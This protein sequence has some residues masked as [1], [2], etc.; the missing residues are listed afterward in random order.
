[1]HRRRDLLA[2]G[3]AEH[4]LRR[5]LRAG[6]LV[7]V[8]RGAYLTDAPDGPDRAGLLHLARLG[9][10]DLAP[11]AVVSHVSAALLHGLPVWNVPLARL[12]TTRPRRT[13]GRRGTVAH[14]H[15]ASLAVD[16]VVV[17]GALPVTTVA[18]TL[19]DLARTLP[20]AEAVAILDAALHR[21]LVTRDELADALARAT[22]WPGTP[23]AARAV[24]F[25]DAGS[26]SV[27]ESRSRVAM[28]LAGL[29]APVLQ[30]PVL[31]ADGDSLG[32][33]DFA[34]PAAAAV[35]EFDGRVK[36]GRLLRPGQDPGEVVFAE[37]VR[38]DAI[39]DQR[40]GMTRWTWGD[41]AD[42]APVAARLRR[43]IG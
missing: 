40:L 26:M 1:M 38:E 29:P 13:G 24:R 41:L 28:H 33:V 8:G 20:F 43:L 25:A 9:A 27:G 37:K 23:A 6:H 19:L 35:A 34:W 10:A 16:E 17:V 36:Y 39:R 32:E 4:E 11:D 31:T 3:I 2:A 22:C 5:M 18:R 30:W 15:A 21:H 42:F 14:V 7:P 12:H